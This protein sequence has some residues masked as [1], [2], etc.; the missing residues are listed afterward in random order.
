MSICVNIKICNYI[1]ILALLIMFSLYLKLME[2][3][4]R[5]DSATTQ[6]FLSIL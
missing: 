4:V 6:V 1:Q 2:A 5:L 3:A